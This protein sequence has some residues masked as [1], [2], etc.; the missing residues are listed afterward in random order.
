MEKLERKRLKRL[1][2]LK[3]QEAKKKGK[4]TKRSSGKEKT[5]YT[6]GGQVIRSVVSGGLPSL[7]KRR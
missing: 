7:G 6:V 1:R 3:K 5:L 4:Q 2:Y